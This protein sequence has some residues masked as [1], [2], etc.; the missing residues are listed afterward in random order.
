[1]EYLSTLFKGSRWC[2]LQV[3]GRVSNG[4]LLMYVANLLLVT[5]LFKQKGSGGAMMI[6]KEVQP[7]KDEGRVVHHLKP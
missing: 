4:T 3:S 5:K 1:M 2:F 6:R 7:V